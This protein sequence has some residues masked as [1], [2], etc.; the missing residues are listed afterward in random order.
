M[1]FDRWENDNFDFKSMFD[2]NNADIFFDDAM[3]SAL[4]TSCAFV[5][6]TR[7]EKNDNGQ[8]IRFQVIDGRNATGIIDD[9]TKLLVEGY[10]VLERDDND[11]P[12]M[13][14]YLTPG[15]TE[16]YQQGIEEPIAV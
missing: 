10:A 1:Q 3:L 2:Q 11:E 8:K 9:Y 13:W 14:A 16:V 5:L 15:R 12:L 7:G 4:I 6:V